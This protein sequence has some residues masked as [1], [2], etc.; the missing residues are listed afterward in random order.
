MMYFLKPTTHAIPFFISSKI[1]PIQMLFFESVSNFMFDISNNL[2]PTTIRDSFI[3]SKSV[4]SY[5]TRASSSD[6]FHIK[7]SRLTQQCNSFTR[8]GAKV[9]NCFPSH[10]Y[11]LN[12]PVFKRKIREALFEV[13]DIEDNYVEAP[14]LLLKMNRHL[15]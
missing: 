1:L 15:K 3:K 2:A 13:L 11:K 9:W 5:N 12:K 8:F 10:M 7:Y 14:I 6:K 4:H